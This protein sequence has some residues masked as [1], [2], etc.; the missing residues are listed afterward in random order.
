MRISGYPNEFIVT[1]RGLIIGKQ[2]NQN[3][4][5]HVTTGGVV[6]MMW[7]QEPRNVNRL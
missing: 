2:K 5:R 7:S 3:Q 4:R 1:T 6:R